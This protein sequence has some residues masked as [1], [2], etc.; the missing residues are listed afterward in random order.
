MAKN[1]KIRT[2]LDRK[3][4]S[5]HTQSSSE[6]STTSAAHLHRA[7]PT[8]NNAT[9]DSYHE[10]SL[11][12]ANRGIKLKEK[13]QDTTKSDGLILAKII[14]QRSLAACTS[15]PVNIYRLSCQHPPYY[16]A[17]TLRG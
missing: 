12:V 8:H 11:T 10:D 3:L 4:S 17:K 14:E 1:V 6:I 15:L 2:F 5:T 16:L 9:S 13:K 7:K